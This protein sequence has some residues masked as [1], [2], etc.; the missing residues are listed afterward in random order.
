MGM[1]E[2]ELE[3]VVGDLQELVGEPMTGAWQ[4]RRDRIVLRLGPAL[5][6]FVPRGPFAR[7]HTIGQ[8]SRNPANPFSF[9][10]ACRAHLR[11]PLRGVTKQPHDRVVD[12]DFGEHRLHLRLTGRSGGLWILRGEEIVAAYDGPA[13]TALPPLPPPPDAPRHSEPRFEPA[14]GES[15]D[16]AAAR[17]FNRKEAEHRRQERR[18]LLGRRLRTRLQREGRLL[19]ALGEDL[20][21]AEG[22]PEARR[23]ADAVAAVMHT[24]SRGQS[25]VVA[26]D[27][28]E[29]GKTHTISLDPRRSPGENLERLYGRARRLERMGDRVLEHMEQ[30]EQRIGAIE[31]ALAVV[32]DADDA[33]LGRLEELAPPERR[34]R[35][36]SHDDPWHTW[37]GPH[38]QR[39][40]VGRNA[41]GNR[42]LTFQRARGDDVWMHVRSRPGAH[43]LV[44][45]AK[46]RTADLDLL[47]AAAQIT[48]LHAGVAVGVKADVQ[49]TK[50]RNIRSIK[51]ADDGKVMVLD[52]RVLHVE[53]DPGALVGWRRADQ[54]VFDADALAAASSPRA[55]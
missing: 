43:V 9:Q 32:D 29:P 35:P 48:L 7:V 46:G 41:K 6:L 55:G 24:L 13:P 42:R 16:R 4:H 52:E 26:D 12:F 5:L 10:G 23:R 53:R 47:L 18:R 2:A 30:V 15:W 20:E 49:Y 37:L 27:L 40:L 14:A 1:N 54:D 3:R 51:G 11:T 22:A 34:G 17:F 19:Q 45:L 28:E 44:P 33:T 25:Q 39:V 50:A 36:I 8:K 38:D 31:A 21:K